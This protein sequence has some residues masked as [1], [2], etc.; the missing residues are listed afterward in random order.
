MNK[1][2]EIS[3]NTCHD[4]F[5]LCFISV[6]VKNLYKYVNVLISQIEK[7]LKATTSSYSFFLILRLDLFK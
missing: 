7:F 6:N 4:F 1:L 3:N 2:K 5:N